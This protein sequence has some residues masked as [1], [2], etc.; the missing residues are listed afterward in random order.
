MEEVN[1]GSIYLVSVS[2]L[3][4]GVNGGLIFFSK[5]LSQLIEAKNGCDLISFTPLGPLPNLFSGS[6]MK[7][8][9]RIS[10]ASF[11]KYL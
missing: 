6:L 9:L 1:S 8:L 7:N 10:T 4:L 5:M 3:N 2:L 11:D